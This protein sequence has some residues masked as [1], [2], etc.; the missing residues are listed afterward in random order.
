MDGNNNTKKD[1]PIII[2]GNSTLRRIRILRSD[3]RGRIRDLLD[4]ERD[5]H[6]KE[7]S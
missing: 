5:K 6:K 3:S 1:K 4:R 2:L 7:K